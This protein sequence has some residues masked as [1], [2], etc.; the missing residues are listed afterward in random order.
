[1]QSKMSGIKSVLICLLL[2]LYLQGI[3]S[4]KEHSERYEYHKDIKKYQELL[5][6]D[7]KN[8]FYNEQLAAS[9]QGI[10]NI[11]KA[12]EHYRIVVENCP[13]NL[14]S[15]FDLGVCYLVKMDREKALKYMN[16]AIAEAHKRKEIELERM[17]IRSKSEWLQKWESIKKLEWNAGKK[18]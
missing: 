17:F 3:T 15:I 7:P 14:I 6:K 13:D 8:C 12:I 10:N 16:K 4:C 18:K 11:D 5:K 2:V 9:Y 1:M